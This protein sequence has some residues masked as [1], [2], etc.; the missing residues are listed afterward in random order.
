MKNSS[1]KLFVNPLLSYPPQEVNGDGD[2]RAV[3]NVLAIHRA[4]KIEI[5]IQLGSC[6]VIGVVYGSRIIQK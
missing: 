4:L 1:T 5:Q 3:K 6:V 2:F